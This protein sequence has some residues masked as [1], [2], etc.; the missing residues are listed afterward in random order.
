MRRPLSL[1]EMHFSFIIFF[2]SFVL[3]GIIIMKNSYSV[4]GFSLIM[5]AIVSLFFDFIYILLARFKSRD[6][7]AQSKR[8]ITRAII[9]IHLGGRANTARDFYRQAARS[10]LA[11]QS[12]NTIIFYSWH[13]TPISLNK[14]FGIS[15]VVYPTGFELFCQKFLNI[16]RLTHG[17]GNP[18]IK[19]VIPPSSLTPTQLNKLERWAS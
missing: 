18:V 14:S 10:I 16:Y 4:F 19:V 9:E 17:N 3:L 2:V 7:P 6:L 8:Y 11:G 12:N 13:I 1:N 5:I 15:S